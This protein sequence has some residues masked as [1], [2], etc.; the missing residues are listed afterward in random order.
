MTAAPAATYSPCK[1]THQTCEQTSTGKNPATPHSLARH[2]PHPPAPQPQQLQSPKH[3]PLC[4]QHSLPL[5]TPPLPCAPKQRKP[6]TPLHPTSYC[7]PTHPSRGQISQP[8]TPHTP[9]KRVRDTETAHHALGL[10][11]CHVTSHTV[12]NSVTSHFPAM[13]LSHFLSPP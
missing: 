2:P 1:G 5:P 7:Q 12:C 11:V 9:Q 4:L 10:S 3:R 13:P 8:P 6:S